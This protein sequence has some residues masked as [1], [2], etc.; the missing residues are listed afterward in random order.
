MINNK[1][2]IVIGHN[3]ESQGAV[4]KDTGETE[5]SF[6]SRLSLYMEEFA[7]KKYPDMET[8]VFRRMPM[9]SYKREINRVYDE[10]D[11]W[12]ANLT[13]ELHFNSAADGSASGTETLTSGTPASMAAAVA[14]NSEIVATLGLRDRG[15]KT[16][17]SG[18]GS[19]SLISGRAP[20]IL[21]EPFFGSSQKGLAATDEEY[22]ER[23]IAFA[24]IRGAAQALDVMPRQDLT[25]SR[26]IKT[27][28][29]TKNVAKAG[30]AAGA[31]GMVAAAINNSG[32]LD[33]A[34]QTADVADRYGLTEWLPWIAWG[35]VGLAVLSLFII[36]TAQDFIKSYR[37]ED[38]E[39]FNGS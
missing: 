36:P 15:V 19:Q 35:G 13:M 12:G 21:V 17:R 39:R 25:G 3:A 2:A 4:R 23:G 32:L 10:T 34:N 7:R 28:N 27:A 29:Q 33:A 1:L 37:K 6:N 24:Y 31:T 9:G 30:S 5:Y 20:A 14:V 22:E 11:A 18:R 8:R 26:T 38:Q 16:R